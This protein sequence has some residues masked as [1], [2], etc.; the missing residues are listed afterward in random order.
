MHLSVLKKMIDTDLTKGEITKKK[1][2]K[3]SFRWKREENNQIKKNLR[4]MMRAK[5]K[6]KIVMK[7]IIMILILIKKIK[8]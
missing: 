8:I 6:K 7:T 2:K 3:D 5:C 4:R 1:L